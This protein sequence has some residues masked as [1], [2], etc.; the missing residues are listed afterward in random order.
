[1]E[2]ACALYCASIRLLRS[3]SLFTL[4]RMLPRKAAALCRFSLDTAF[5]YFFLSFAALRSPALMLSV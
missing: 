4:L 1:M 3:A 5:L 2:M